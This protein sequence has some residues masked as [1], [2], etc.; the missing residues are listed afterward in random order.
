MRSLIKC[1]LLPL[2]GAISSAAFA[3]SPT[4]LLPSDKRYPAAKAHFIAITKANLKDADSAKIGSVI[5]C[6]WLPDVKLA[7]LNVNAKNSFGA[8]TGY[9]IG[10]VLDDGTNK[11]VIFINSNPA[12]PD[13]FRDQRALLSALQACDPAMEAYKLG[14]FEG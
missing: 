11:G 10:S 4:Y 7:L 2:I 14:G 8:Y 12:G 1:L 13:E 3:Q 9:K 5:I 6:A